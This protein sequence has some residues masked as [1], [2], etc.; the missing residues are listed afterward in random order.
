MT[1]RHPWQQLEYPVRRTLHRVPWPDVPV[2]PGPISLDE[3]KD[4]AR[5][6]TDAED[7][8]AETM[9]AAAIDYAET[10][11]R[12]SIQFSQWDLVLDSFPSG[13]IELR[14]PPVLDVLE[15]EYRST[16][17]VWTPIDDAEFEVEID[18]DHA[19]LDHLEGESWPSVSS[20]SRSVRVRYRAGYRPHFETTPT[21]PT[22][23]VISPNLK[24]GILELFTFRFDTRGIGSTNRL[25]EVA[26]PSA[27]ETVFW[28]ERVDL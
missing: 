16:A 3:A 9:I 26:V 27:I 21:T 10:A 15:L 4:Y 2:I 20:A 8:V 19:T 24:V 1:W 25:I 6:T 5:I 11:T 22:L 17:G 13:M 23:P 7:G 12:R 28:A 18:G 14:R